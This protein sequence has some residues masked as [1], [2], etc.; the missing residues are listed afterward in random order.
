MNRLSLRRLCHLYVL[1]ALLTA[2]MLSALPYRL[3]ALILL[4]VMLF[5]TFRP[6]K[7]RLNLVI[8]ALALFLVPLAFEPLLDY[9]AYD[10]SPIPE[11]IVAVGTLPIIYLLDLNLRHHA[12]GIT[13]E[14]STSE[15]YPT[16]TLRALFGLALGILL[17]SLIVGNDI[18]LST[19]I[20]LNL[21]LL[22]I[23]IRVL[24]AVPRLP[25]DVP[26]VQKRIIA[27]TKAEISLYVTSKALITLHFALS[28]VDSWV[29]IRSQRLTLNKVKIELN[30]TVTPPLAGPSR[31]Q[32][33]AS[34]IDQ[35]GFIQTNQV[36]EP[37]NLYV[38]PRARYAAW[39]AMRYLQKPGTAGTAAAPPKVTSI[40]K[41]GV[42]Y[43]QSRTY[44]PGDSLKDIDW[45]HTLKLNQTV[46]KQY[47]E[48][49]VEAAIIAVNLSVTNSEEA[50]KLTF[51]LISTALTL[52]QEGIPSALAVY[53]HQ[54][55]VL[56]TPL[57]DP[58][59]ILRETLSLVKGVTLVDFP[60]RFLE[61]PDIGK[62]RRN[63]TLL[64]QSTSQ[65][66]QRLFS[67][68]DFE[69]QA[70]SEATRGHP[71]TIALTA[72]ANRALPPAVL[73][74]VSQLNHDTEALMMIATKLTKRG[75]TTVHIEA[76]EDHQR[77]NSPQIWPIN[78]ALERISIRR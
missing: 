61:P 72:V 6:L 8:M 2:S 65:S 46:I 23:L 44:Q 38:I 56:T 16:V 33:L 40:A 4:L 74:L 36:I 39:L 34:I 69:Y 26:T 5:V 60:H 28:P 67:L 49:G 73:I 11:L 63:M 50:D 24:R 29:R 52:A 9:L 21:Y 13:L 54:E 32:L 19:A 1:L 42:E 37:I 62:L 14:H 12:Q 10:A 41:R 3:F 66:T 71:A 51:N 17:L 57:S 31:P 43:Y 58:R 15:R 75:F 76:T 30:A 35:W 55:V 25:L 78:R 48:A 45:K 70:I 77:K 27:G 64:R 7:P 47:I 20:I 68:L 59:E 18:L 53:N 22:A